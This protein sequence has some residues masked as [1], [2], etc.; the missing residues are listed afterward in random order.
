[1]R[2]W[3]DELIL[4][5]NRSVSIE[6]LAFKMDK[7]GGNTEDRVYV[8]KLAEQAERYDGKHLILPLHRPVAI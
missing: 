1:M 6:S 3:S 2:E 4:Q 5:E 7:D 8:A